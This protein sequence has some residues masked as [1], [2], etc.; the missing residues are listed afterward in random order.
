MRQPL[1]SLTVAT[2]DADRLA[3]ASSSLLSDEVNVRTVE[4]TELADHDERVS[5]QLPVNARAAGPRLGKD[6]QKVIKASKAGDWSVATTGPWSAAAYRWS[7]GSTRWNWSRGRRRLRT[8]SVCCASGGFVSLD[9]VLDDELVADGAVSD[10]LRLVQQARKDAGLEVSDRIE[11]KVVTDDQV[12]RA[13]MAGRWPWLAEQ[14]L[15]LNEASVGEVRTGSRPGAADWW[16]AP[17]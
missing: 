11:L 9:T 3:A 17:A 12:A 2:R 4:L 8:R 1:A 7:R 16:W 15:A 14:V 6:V 10:L 13:A 5:R